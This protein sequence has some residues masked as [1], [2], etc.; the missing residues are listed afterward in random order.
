MF[1]LLKQLGNAWAVHARRRLTVHHAT[2]ADTFMCFQL[3]LSRSPPMTRTRTAGQRFYTV[4]KV[5]VG[6]TTSIETHACDLQIKSV[7]AQGH[8]VSPSVAG[9]WLTCCVSGAGEEHHDTH[10]QA[11]L[12]N[13][14]AP[15]AGT[16]AEALSALNQ[17]AHAAR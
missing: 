7:P 13:Q 10:H 12:S 8:L 14:A 2:F 3:S 1:S 11:S 4:Q 5:C 17:G 16:Q 6:T 15:C 9:W